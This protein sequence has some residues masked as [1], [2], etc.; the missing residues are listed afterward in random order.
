M[1]SPAR[2]YK[3]KDIHVLSDGGSSSPWR[4][5]LLM[6]SAEQKNV[7]AGPLQETEVVLR[8][9]PEVMEDLVLTARRSFNH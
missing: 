3:V 4:I 6:D 1:N 2:D 5:K 9:W 8:I 7:P